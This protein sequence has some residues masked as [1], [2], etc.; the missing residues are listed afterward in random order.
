MN[1]NPEMEKNAG[2]PDGLGCCYHALGDF[3]NALLHY[4]DAIEMD[5]KNTDFLMH[6]SQCE[7][8][9]KNFVKSID[10]L[11]NALDVGHQDP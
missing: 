6:L 10:H 5:P 3:E 4:N 1:E 11:K 7:Y 8:D 2:I 9:Q